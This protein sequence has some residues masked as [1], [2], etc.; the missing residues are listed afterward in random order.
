[1]YHVQANL[2]TNN[3]NSLSCVLPPTL[4]GL[5]KRMH[6]PELPLLPLLVA[7]SAGG[8]QSSEVKS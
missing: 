3:E 4:V 1:M 6:K 5:I 7:A 8:K 2:P